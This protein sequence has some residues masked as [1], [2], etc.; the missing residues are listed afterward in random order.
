[1]KG[2]RGN[3]GALTVGIGLLVV[4]GI[5]VLGGIGYNMY[6]G[7]SDGTLSV[8]GG[9]AGSVTTAGGGVLA[10][11]LTVNQI[12]KYTEV[13]EGSNSLEFWDKNADISDSSKSPREEIQ[14]SGGTNTTTAISTILSDDTQATKDLYIDGGSSYY[15]D[16]VTQWMLNYNAETGKGLLVVDGHSSGGAQ[17]VDIGTF[18]DFD[19]LEAVDTGIVA[20]AAAG[21]YNYSEG[22]GD[23]TVYIRLELGNDE[24]DSEIRDMVFCVGD[25]DGDLEGNEITSLTISRYTGDSIGTINS[26]IL[27][28]FSDAAGTGSTSC[29]PIGDVIG[30]KKG[31]YQIDMEINEANLESGEEWEFLVD[32]LGS[33]KAR[34]YP[35]RDLKATV[36]DVTIQQAS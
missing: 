25:D 31:V 33:V 4:L 21:T 14:L 30:L 13:K 9:T 7:D 11:Q 20:N 17:S 24:V 6:F 32:D 34:S 15:D 29:T 1:M 16:K 19:T 23:G 18:A 2:K 26:D 35:S 27:D 10:E 3:A 8:S 5:F 36:E 28:L 22:T 12:N